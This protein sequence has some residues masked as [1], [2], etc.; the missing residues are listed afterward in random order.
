MGVGIV[1]FVDLL[2]LFS[3][4]IGLHLSGA[5]AGVMVIVRSAWAV[6]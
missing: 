4:L 3:G 1:Q 5:Q 2:G 6:S